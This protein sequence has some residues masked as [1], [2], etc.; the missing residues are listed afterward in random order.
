MS[1]R[2]PAPSPSPGLLAPVSSS[3]S[4]MMQG[5]QLTKVHCRVHPS[6][7]LTMLDSHGR[8]RESNEFAIG[9]LLGTVTS[10][11]GTKG[12]G[13]VVVEIVDCFANPYHWDRTTTALTIQK[14][15]HEW[16]LKLR[17]KINPKL[18]VVGW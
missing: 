6:V 13:D 10:E 12:S 7:L 15:Q 11:G 8:L 2:V 14:E 1:I 5:F 17:E 16:M 18:S 4:M 9:T 3:S